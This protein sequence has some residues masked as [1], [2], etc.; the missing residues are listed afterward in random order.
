M[1]MCNIPPPYDQGRLALGSVSY[2][3]CLCFAFTHYTSCGTCL[4]SAHNLPLLEVTGR[5]ECPERVSPKA[6]AGQP[7]AA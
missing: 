7:G 2:Q 3:L 6:Y 4:I 1:S 5:W